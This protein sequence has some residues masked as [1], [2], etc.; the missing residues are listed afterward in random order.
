MGVHASDLKK[1]LCKFKLQENEIP[2]DEKYHLYHLGRASVTPRT[3][4]WFHWTWLIQVN[5][6]SVYIADSDNEWDVY[7]SLK[8]TGEPYVKGSK[9]EAGVYCD[10]V[11]LA[12]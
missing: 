3:L 11:I 10:R 5:I 9:S 6:S 12:K 4:I 1:P 7:V 8:L 2:Q